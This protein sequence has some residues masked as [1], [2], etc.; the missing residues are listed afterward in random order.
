MLI[1]SW[2]NLKIALVTQ[3]KKK[4]KEKGRNKEERENWQRTANLKE[5]KERKLLKKKCWFERQTTKASTI[6]E[7]KVL[8]NNTNT[9]EKVM[10]DLYNKMPA[11]NAHPKY[12][13]GNDFKI[14]QTLYDTK[15]FEVY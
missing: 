7:I 1:K 15:H 2:Y 10:I 12:Q 14:T 11:N 6:E 8:N 9:D 4:K 13:L 3:Q 5:K